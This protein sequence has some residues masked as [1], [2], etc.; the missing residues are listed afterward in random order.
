[1]TDLFIHYDYLVVLGAVVMAVLQNSVKTGKGFI[2][3]LKCMSL[4]EKGILLWKI[5]WLCN[6]MYICQ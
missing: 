1:L 2:S 5:L 3:F 6:V 4:H